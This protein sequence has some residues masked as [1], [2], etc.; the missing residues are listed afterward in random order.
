MLIIKYLKC[1]L[2]GKQMAVRF[3][4][5][6]KKERKEEGVWNFELDIFI[7]PHFKLHIFILIVKIISLD[8][9]FPLFF[10]SREF[11]SWVNDDTKF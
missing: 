8:I 10:F 11:I 5:A 9:S 3:L 7:S 1:H 4:W 6:K 2:I